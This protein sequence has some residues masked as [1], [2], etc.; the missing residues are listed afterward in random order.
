MLKSGHWTHI[1]KKSSTMWSICIRVVLVMIFAL[2]CPFSM[3]PLMVL[4]WDSDMETPCCPHRIRH[5]RGNLNIL[6]HVFFCFWLFLFRPFSRLMAKHACFCIWISEFSSML[7]FDYKILIEII[8]M[9]IIKSF[10][11]FKVSYLVRVSITMESP[12]ILLGILKVLLSFIH[13]N[14]TTNCQIL[15]SNYWCLS[16]IISCRHNICMYDS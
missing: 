2:H 3:A 5:H 15:V 6:I 8:M 16:L 10:L 14:F 4:A 7:F 1:Q 13:Y 9:V 12:C 11:G